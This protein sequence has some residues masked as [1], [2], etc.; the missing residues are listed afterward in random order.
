LPYYCFLDIKS[1]PRT[2]CRLLEIV[3]R[4]RS[5]TGLQIDVVELSKNCF[6]EIKSFFFPNDNSKINKA[7]KIY[8]VR[9]FFQALG[10]EFLKVWNFSLRTFSG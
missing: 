9:V 7:A 1:F 4:C 8:K 6:G 2:I 10:K 5:A 3:S